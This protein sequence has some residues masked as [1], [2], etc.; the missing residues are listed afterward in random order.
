MLIKSELLEILC[1]PVS[2]EP[3]KLISDQELSNLN[4]KI[5]QKIVINQNKTL[6]LAPF[7]TGLIEHKN[8]IFYPIQDQI[9]ILLESESVSLKNI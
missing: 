1:C 4:A 3:L 8:Q 2:K 5:K 7:E 9:P 6:I